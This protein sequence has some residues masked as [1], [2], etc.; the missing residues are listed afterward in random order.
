MEPDEIAALSSDVLLDPLINSQNGDT[1]SLQLLSLSADTS[2]RE[3]LDAVC[4][5]SVEAIDGAKPLVKP[6]NNQENT[7]LLQHKVSWPKVTIGRVTTSKSVE[8]CG[9]RRSELRCHK[10][11]HSYSDSTELPNYVSVV[12]T[13]DSKFSPSVRLGLHPSTVDQQLSRHSSYI[14]TTSSGAATSNLASPFCGD[15]THTH[16]LLQGNYSPTASLAS[17][18]IELPLQSSC[19]SDDSTADMFRYPDLSRSLPAPVSIS[20]TVDPKAKQGKNLVNSLTVIEKQNPIKA[21]VN[22]VIGMISRKSSDQQ[23]SSNRSQSRSTTHSP[24]DSY[25]CD[26]LSDTKSLSDDVEIADEA[27]PEPVDAISRTVMLPEEEIPENSTT[28]KEMSPVES[29]SSSVQDVSSTEQSSKHH[30]HPTARKCKSFP[31]S[32]AMAEDLSPQDRLRMLLSVR[33]NT[34]QQSQEQLNSVPPLLNNLGPATMKST[35][36]KRSRSITWAIGCEPCH[37]DLGKLRRTSFHHQHTSK[38]ESSDN[39]L[40]DDSYNNTSTPL[41]EMSVSCM[42]R[43][44]LVS[45]DSSS[46]LVPGSPTVS[47]PDLQDLTSSSL[48]S[49]SHNDD[50]PPCLSCHYHHNHND[51]RNSK[52]GHVVNNS[53]SPLDTLDQ[54]IRYSGRL[55]HCT[56]MKYVNNN[57]YCNCH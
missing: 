36:R 8:S 56:S 2:L 21:V 38:S 19:T 37:L 31:N 51:G 34:E 35:N 32:G 10:R 4:Q 41:N 52:D 24:S 33:K 12:Q 47:Q 49:E 53:V 46:T 50:K 28:D 27:I 55:H 40:P 25:N 18:N 1:Q 48:V 43:N 5:L 42:S 13:G 14:S 29:E 22:R 20:S 17:C 54:Y 45:L 11:R 39:A 9:P 6:L 7:A 30:Q 23:K 44:T 57:L 16:N 3:K 26:G 15:T